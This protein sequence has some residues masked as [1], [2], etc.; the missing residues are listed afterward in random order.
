MPCKGDTALIKRL[1]THTERLYEAVDGLKKALSVL[2]KEVEAAAAGYRNRVIP[3][4]QALRQEADA[5][6][7]LTDKRCWP[8]PTY[9]DLLFY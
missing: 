2:P 9:S 1:S 8:Y 5:L 4:M 3:A 6:E 7:E